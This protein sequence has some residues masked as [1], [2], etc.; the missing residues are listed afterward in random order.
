M[1][2]FDSGAVESKELEISNNRFSFLSFL[3]NDAA[4]GMLVFENQV[5]ILRQ[6]SVNENQGEDFKN[7]SVSGVTFVGQ[8]HTT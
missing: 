3:H 6:S 4:L 2:Y 5:L 7:E 8:V 1:D